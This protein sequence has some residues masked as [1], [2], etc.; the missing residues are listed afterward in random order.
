MDALAVLGNLTVD[1][2]RT[3]RLLADQM[4]AMSRMKDEEKEG[5]CTH[6]KAD[7]FII[8]NAKNDPFDLC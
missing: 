7:Q 2:K 6:G 1:R 8:R 5:E 3:T 4:M